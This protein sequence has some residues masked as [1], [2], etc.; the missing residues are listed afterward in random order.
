M[1][2]IYRKLAEKIAALLLPHV[3]ESK[4]DEH[5]YDRLRYG[6]DAVLRD[7]SKFLLLAIITIPLGLFPYL[8]V[9]VIP[10]AWIGR[11][12]FGFHLD[13][14]LLCTLLG[15]LYYIGSTL[16]SLYL[17]IPIV[18]KVGILVVCTTLIRQYAPVETKKRPIPEPQKPELKRKAEIRAYTIAVLCILS[19]LLLVNPA[20]SN[21]LLWAVVCRTVN[22]LP[23]KEVK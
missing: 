4:R 9:F 21:L 18:I 12:S 10:Y 17:M 14:S 20:Y 16:L 23:W 6:A 2:D 1:S 7:F 5:T 8:V 22:V 3:K 19:H 11:V 13:S 15:I